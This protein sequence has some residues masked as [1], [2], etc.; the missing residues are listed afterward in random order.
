MN[1]RSFLSFVAASAASVAC[2][3]PSGVPGTVRVGFLANLTHAP[4]IVALASGALQRALPGVKLEVRTFR[5]GPRVCEALLGNAIDIAVSGPAPIV[6]MHARHSGRPFV[7]MSGVASG[8]ASLIALPSIKTP[9]DLAGKRV[10][11][12]QI[13]ST[14]DISLRKWLSRNGLATKDRGG[15]IVVDAL[16]SANIMEEMRRG[17]IAAAWMPEP[18]A[19]RVLDERIAVRLL[20]ERELWS[21]HRF[22]TALLVA[23]RQFCEQRAAEAN[24]I[25]GVVQAQL[26]RIDPAFR[27]ATF[28]ELKRLTGKGLPQSVIESAWA[29]VDYLSD[30]LPKQLAEIAADARALGYVPSADV[31]GLLAT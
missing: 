3:K 27:E 7:I 1:R 19:S 15:D 23:R 30:P 24:A 11:T 25:K 29:R 17:A 20:D 4:M 13:G 9:R 18:W 28:A 21:E 5:A 31:S 22:P 2:R 14:Q 16:A 6:S 10:A 26:T 12:P 8:G